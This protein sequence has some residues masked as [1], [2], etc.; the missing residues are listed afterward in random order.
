[1]RPAPGSAVQGA[2]QPLPILVLVL[3]KVF[4]SPAPEPN[5]PRVYPGYLPQVNMG[6]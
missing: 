6:N 1:M 2:H 5:H 3:T 4:N